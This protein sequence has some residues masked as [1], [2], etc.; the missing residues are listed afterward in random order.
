MQKPAASRRAVQGV[1]LIELLVVVVIVGIL[2]AI[3]YPS[4]REHVNRTRRSDGTAALLNVAQRLERCFTQF[5]AYNNA[6]CAVAL[7]I[8]SP[9]GFYEIGFEDGPTATT[10]QLSATPKGHQTG[11][12]CGTLMLTHAG[13]R[14][15]TGDASAKCW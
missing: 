3:A 14:S 1:T 2:T 10:Y 15:V 13:A 6:G 4:Y 11:D 8:D 9:E 7:P 5:N 12:A